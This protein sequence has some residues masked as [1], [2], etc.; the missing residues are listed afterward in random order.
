MKSI[1]PICL[2]RVCGFVQVAVPARQGVAAHGFHVGNLECWCTWDMGGFSPFYFE[3]RENP[4]SEP[5]CWG[6]FSFSRVA[7]HCL[8]EWMDCH[9]LR[10]VSKRNAW[11]ITFLSLLFFFLIL[12]YKIQNRTLNYP[13]LSWFSSFSFPI[14]KEEYFLP[15]NTIAGIGE[16]PGHRKI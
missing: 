1:F 3:L 10:K 9:S 13:F 5:R 6:Y 7:F 14:R 15:Q 11:Q 2:K 16:R 4:E 8:N 12:S